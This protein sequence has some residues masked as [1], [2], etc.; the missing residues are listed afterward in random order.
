MTNVKQV[1]NRH[2]GT[3]TPSAFSGSFSG[4]TTTGGNTWSGATT[5]KTITT[6]GSYTVTENPVTGYTAS[7]SS[8]C[9]GS[10]SSG[11]NKTCTITNQDDAGTLNVRKNA[12][13]TYS[14]PATA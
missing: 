11:S 3:A 8:D 9:S 4:I 12:N 5:T 7:Y 1:V 2:D 6:I 10:I 13:N 14:D